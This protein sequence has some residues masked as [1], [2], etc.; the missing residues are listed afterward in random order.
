MITDDKE[1]CA[2]KRLYVCLGVAICLGMIGAAWASDLPAMGKTGDGT[3]YDSG[4]RNGCGPVTEVS[5]L[6]YDI[7]TTLAG[8]GNDCGIRDAADQIYHVTIPQAGSYTFS[9]CG[10]TALTN[11]FIYLLDGCCSGNEIARDNDGCGTTGGPSLLE[12]IT[13]TAGSYYLVVEAADANSEGPYSLHIAACSNAC[14]DAAL[15]PGTEQ[16]DTTHYRFVQTVDGDSLAPY[17]TGPWV[18]SRPCAENGGYYGFDYFCWFNDDFGWVHIW[19]QYNDP[20]VVSVDSAFVYICAWDVDEP[21]EPNAAARQVPC[22]IDNVSLFA[23]PDLPAVLPHLEGSSQAWSVTR[24]PVPFSEFSSDG[25]LNVQVNID[26]YSQTCDWA[27]KIHRSQFVVYYTVNRPPFT[28]EGIASGCVTADSNLC[29]TVTGP[30]PPDPDGDG[31][32]YVY[33][34]YLRDAGL[35]TWVL[36][37]NYTGNCLPPGVAQTGESWKCEVVAVDDH[38]ARSGPWSTE[39]LV[40]E[41][42]GSNPPLGFDYGDLDTCYQTGTVNQGGPSNP[43]FQQ[44]VAWLGDTVTV[45]AVPKILNLDDGDDGVVFVDPTM[46]VPCQQVCVDVKI[47]TGPA[48]NPEIHHLYLYGFKDGSFP[49]NCSFGD[50][51]CNGEAYEC[52]IP[53]V[54]ITGL[55]AN[56]DTTRRFCFTDPGVMIGQGRY[57]GVFRFRLLTEHVSCTQAVATNDPV[58]GETEDYIMTDLQLPVE[59]LGFDLTQEGDAVVLRWSTASERENDHFRIERRTSG[60]WSTVAAR[61]PGAGSSS[62]MHSYSYRDALVEVG[63]TYE[64][65]LI[66]VDF[67]GTAQALGVQSIPVMQ[68][69]P[70]TVTE[71]RLY[72]N[73]PNPFNPTTTI[74]FDLAEAGQVSLKVYDIMGREVAV[75][76]NGYLPAGRH[77]LVFDAQGLPSGLYMFKLTAGNFSDMKKMVLLK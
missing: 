30:Q 53:G 12:C 72:P 8:A 46:W 44:N 2:M 68:H 39:F 18:D 27:V 11:T 10:T 65:R 31:V 76:A 20:S 5:S 37:P 55:Q 40:Q 74:A 4:T 21:C 32:T 52:I 15:L 56:S 38:G 54:E 14:D 58:G 59:L 77:R 29:V 71:Y 73:Y 9:L 6:P 42:C 1:D 57:D 66:S 7:S 34:W 33:Q 22:E 13:L 60:S 24:F 36:Q 75:L 43:I 25:H 35:D 63:T 70:T 69:D 51:F 45:D 16:L 48:Y 3:T 49:P 64:Y 17:Y 50:R 26:A 41:D 62:T 28:P 61:I 23:N 47:R 19:P 67:N